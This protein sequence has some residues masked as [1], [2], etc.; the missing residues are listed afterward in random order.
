M[1]FNDEH[2]KN[3]KSSIVSTLS[4]IITDANPEHYRNAEYPIDVTELGIVMFF[5]KEQ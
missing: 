4:P 1:F 3:A 5:N 2:E